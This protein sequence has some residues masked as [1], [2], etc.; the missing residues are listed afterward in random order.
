MVH[1]VGAELFPETGQERDDA[2]GQPAGGR[3][4][5]GQPA[6]GGLRVTP[7]SPRV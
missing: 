5:G 3:P 1:E 2:V 6:P 4:A 7:V